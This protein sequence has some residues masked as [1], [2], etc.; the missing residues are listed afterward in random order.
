MTESKLLR[1]FHGSILMVAIVTLI[2]ILNGKFS[3]YETIEIVNVNLDLSRKCAAIKSFNHFKV[4]I[5]G[6]EYPK[7]IP[8]YHNKSINFEYL[9]N[10]TFSSNTKTILMWNEFKGLPLIDHVFGKSE[11]F[12]RLR[13]PVTSCELTNDRSRINHSDLVLFH[14]RKPIDSFPQYRLANQRWV[15]VI[16]ESPVYCSKCA[17]YEDTFNLSATYTS[18]SDFTSIYYTDSGLYWDTPDANYAPIDATLNKKDLAA[19]MISYCEARSKRIQYIE[20]MREYIPVNIYGRCG[21]PCPEDQDCRKYVAQAHKFFFAF[22]NSFCRDYVTEKFFS[23]LKYN[24]VPVVYGLGNYDEYVPRSGYINVLDFKTPKELADYLIY[25]DGNNTAYNAYFEWK[26]YLKYDPNH[27]IAGYLCEMCIKLHLEDHTGIIQKKKFNSLQKY[28]GLRNNCK[29]IV[30]A[31]KT[32]E[33][34]NSEEGT[35]PEWA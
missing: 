19:V 18:F 23:T 16:Y 13:C 33:L 32:Y 25:L 7:R 31:N 6:V 20:I 30:F 9:N 14:L 11:V 15:H 3:Q 17:R 21:K 4:V 29:D 28:F 27:P 12:G 26:K 1:I 35:F 8:L 5:D 10:L 24:T 34:V 22:E 2:F